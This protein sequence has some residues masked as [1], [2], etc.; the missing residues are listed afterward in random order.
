MK[1]KFLFQEDRQPPLVVSD[2]KR[3]LVGAAKGG[4]EPYM[5][6][7]NLPDVAVLVD[8]NRVKAGRYRRPERA[9][10]PTTCM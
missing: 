4:D 8:K 3:L 10:Q 2:G 5:L 1:R 7:A 6:A 9:W